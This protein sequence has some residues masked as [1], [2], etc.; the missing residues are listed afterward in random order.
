MYVHPRMYRR[1]NLSHCAP[2]LISP[3]PFVSPCCVPH[4]W[5]S[6]HRASLLLLVRHI[7][8]VGSI[9]AYGVG[10]V[11]FHLFQP[12]ARWRRRLHLRDSTAKQP[13]STKQCPTS[14]IRP[15]TEQD[16]DILPLLYCILTL[17]LSPCVCAASW[18]RSPTYPVLRQCLAVFVR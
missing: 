1:R 17:A 15:V 14:L 13:P 8:M 2:M 16:L 3:P 4:V 18:T 11:S 7:V 5:V 9:T 10:A 6:P 12:V